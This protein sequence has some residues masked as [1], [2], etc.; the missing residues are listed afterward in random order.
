[1]AKKK[2]KKIEDLSIF[3]IVILIAG[4]ATLILG[5]YARTYTMFEL[6]FFLLLFAYVLSV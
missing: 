2:I 3:D 6:G 4:I 1:M 5:F